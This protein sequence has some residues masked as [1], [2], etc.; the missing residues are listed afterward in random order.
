MLRKM[1]KLRWHFAQDREPSVISCPV[2][3]V[4][5]AA[6]GSRQWGHTSHCNS[7]RLI[8][9]GSP[10]VREPSMHAFRRRASRPITRAPDLVLDP[11]VGLVQSIAEPDAGGPT[12]IFLDKRVVAV[13]TVHALGG[14]EIVMALEL[15]PG[16]LL[17]D[18][19]QLIDRNQFVAAEVDWFENLAPKDLLSAVQTVV[20]V[21][22]AAC[23]MTVAP[24][25]DL[26][27][28][29]DLGLDDFSADGGRRLFASAHP[30]A[31]RAIDVV[32]ASGA[33]LEPEVFSERAAHAFAE[34]FLPA[35]T[36]FR[37]RGISIGF[38]QSGDVRV[39]LLVGI[40][41]AG[42]GGG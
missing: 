2:S 26:V 17:P 42:G 1:G 6:S 19:H 21:H 5:S 12:K 22:E 3:C 39:A 38:L 14:L 41:N 10:G 23:L 20:D 25:L 16:D 30:G 37:L 4:A 40:I 36:V 8:W 11:T 35:V 28:A 34:E 31:I 13:A 15:D 24:D 9:G 32:E 27:F 33:G 18:V 29:R 7:R